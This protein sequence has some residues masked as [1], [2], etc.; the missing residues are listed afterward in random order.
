[1]ANVKPVELRTGHWTKDEIE[2]RKESENKLKGKNISDKAP[3]KL[4]TNGKK[5]YKYLLTTFPDNFLTEVDYI[6]LE[7]VAN[8]IDMLQQSQ[9]DIKARGIY[10]E[11]GSE[12]PSHRIYDRYFKIFNSMASKLGMSPKDRASLSAIMI[13]QQSEDDDEL[14]KILKS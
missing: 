8:S 13:A 2:A 10:L 6:A 12:N 11:D 1:M 9:A 5:I 14:L 3:T 7:I 4:S